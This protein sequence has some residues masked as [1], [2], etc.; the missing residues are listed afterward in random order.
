[1]LRQNLFKRQKNIMKTVNQDQ[2]LIM[3]KNTNIIHVRHK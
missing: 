2:K 3:L 1:M